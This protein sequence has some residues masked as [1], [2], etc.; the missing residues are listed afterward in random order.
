MQNTDA[1]M[2]PFEDPW[3]ERY[4]QMREELPENETEKK[5]MEI[6]GRGGPIHECEAVWKEAGFSDD[7]FFKFLQKVNEWETRLF[8]KGG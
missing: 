8:C 5:V 6:L 4:R 3:E 1:N 2:K 7:E